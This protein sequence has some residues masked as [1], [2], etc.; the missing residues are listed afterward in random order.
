VN[1]FLAHNSGLGDYIL[2]NGA[3]RYLSSLDEIESIVYL[4]QST[5]NKF[6]HLV[7][8]YGGMDKIR[9]IEEKQGSGFTSQRRKIRIWG[10]RF[11]DHE[12][13][14]FAWNAA[15]WEPSMEIRGLDP[16]RDCWPELFYSVLGAPYSARHEYFHI[17]RNLKKEASLTRSLRLPVDYA[18]CVDRGARPN[19]NLSPPTNLPI[20]KPHD[21]PEILHEY[22]I[23]DWMGVISGASIIYT[24]DTAWMHL[25][26]SMRLNVPKFYYHMRGDY[27]KNVFTSCY[28][29]DKYDN[30]WEIVD[31]H[32]AIL[33]Q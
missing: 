7:R 11:S 15:F 29:N 6:R 27:V 22:D 18:F 16:N 10:K 17:H 8:M 25:I 1:L 32:G 14:A 5:P 23:F 21:Y 33:S 26:K 20:I 24:I 28:I 4:C 3:V 9:L 19:F 30:G 12:S 13:R 2:M 31:K